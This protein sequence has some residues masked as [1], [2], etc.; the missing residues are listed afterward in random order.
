M[1]IHVNEHTRSTVLEHVL[2]MYENSHP[3]N[4]ITCIYILLYLFPTLQNVRQCH[5]FHSIALLLSEHVHLLF[6]LIFLFAL[7]LSKRIPAEAIKSFKALLA[8]KLI[9]QLQ[10]AYCAHLRRQ[11]VVIIVVS[12]R[13]TMPPY[14]SQAREFLLKIF[15]RGLATIR[16]IYILLANRQ[17]C[18]TRHTYKDFYEWKVSSWDVRRYGAGA[19]RARIIRFWY[20]YTFT[21]YKEQVRNCHII[22]ITTT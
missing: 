17:R 14:S 19:E 12:T 5:N 10:V 1:L 21:T 15:R 22:Y 11:T 6:F 4:Y 16:Y 9:T 18:C 2:E 3:W 20:V 13:S 8:G 7:T